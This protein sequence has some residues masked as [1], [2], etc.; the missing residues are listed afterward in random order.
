[1][2]RDKAIGM[3]LLFSI[4]LAVLFT[5]PTHAVTLTEINP[6][7]GAVGTEVRLI[8]TIDTEGGAYTIWFDVDDDGTAVGDTA[9]KTGSAPANSYAVNTTFVVPS[10]VGTDAGRDHKVTLEDDSSTNTHDATFTVETSRE[11]I[12][13][14]YAQ[15]GDVV[16]I[17]MSV[18]GGLAN[19]VSNFTVMVTDPAVT[20]TKNYNV[21]FTTDTNGFGYNITNFPTDF[22]TGAA[23]NFTGNYD[24]VANR[25]LPGKITNAATASF[26][27]GLT[28]ASVYERFETVNV[29]TSGWSLNQNIT[30][31][32]K[33]PSMENVT[34]W[35]PVNA[36]DGTWTGDWM[37]PWDAY[38]GTYTVEVVNATGDEKAVDSIQTFTVGSVALTV[39]FKTAPA[40]PL[41]RTETATAKFMIQYPDSSY[42]DNVTSFDSITVSV[43]Y[44]TTLV[45]T[46]SLSADD[47]GADNNWTVSWKIPWDA[48]LGSGY[49]FSLD[50]DSITD[51]NGNT[52][53]TTAVASNSFIVQA[54]TL[55]VK[56]T[57][58]PAATYMRTQTAVAKI[59][60]TYPDNSLYT[61]ADLGTI[62]VR[63]YQGSTNVANVTLTADDYDSITKQWTISW[64]S[65]WNATLADDYL[66]TIKAYEIT[67]AANPNTGPTADVSTGTFELLEADLNV[68]SINTDKISYTRGEVVTVYFIATYQ[69]G[70]DVT[71]GSATITLTMAN[72]STTQLT[73][74]YVSANGRFEAKYTLKAGDPLGTW[75]ARLEPLGLKDTEN[76]MGPDK[77]KT[78]VFT[79][80]EV[81]PLEVITAAVK[82]TP[83]TVNLKSNGRWVMAH[84]ELPDGY[85]AADIDVST[86]RLDGVVEA[87]TSQVSGEGKLLVKFSRGAVKT[88]I[89]GT[90]GITGS[91]FSS[92][93]LTV[94][95]K[96]A[97]T[98]FQ[99]I[100]TIRVKR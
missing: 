93:N 97:E 50:V 80:T 99:G 75:Y 12:V 34:V 79:V 98:T 74:T 67:D 36:T 63:V 95:G 59:N 47:Y 26:D 10:C 40:S 85:S 9:V 76:N 84:I 25:T 65:P 94:T 68:A 54:T 22:S 64:V 37:I 6:T 17:N 52:G 46:M 77:A 86:I 43:Y 3:L 5:L 14:E 44:N 45:D 35:D 31:T 30:V 81:A 16:A 19:T 38:A 57:Q 73:A 32:I 56:V 7:S 62:K 49:K 89:Q 1:M 23:T 15:E 87:E 53:P 41:Q 2:K 78:A 27:I 42:Y 83:R 82:I 100:A 72:G 71:T 69:N 33:D 91:K 96:V 11:M 39:T 88:H 70:S 13:P 21:S 58:Q 20:E 24:I 92:V 29:Q 51:D 90:I 66:F 55:T 60:I 8:G 28:N 18:T 4:S 61:A 48:V